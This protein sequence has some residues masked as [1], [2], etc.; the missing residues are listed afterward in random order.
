MK[1][2]IANEAG[3]NRSKEDAV[4][5]YFQSWDRKM[6][7]SRLGGRFPAVVLRPVFS[8]RW[9]VAGAALLLAVACLL[10]VNL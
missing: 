4:S 9:L 6:A 10:L 5:S 1:Y 2:P 7:R 3:V 8:W